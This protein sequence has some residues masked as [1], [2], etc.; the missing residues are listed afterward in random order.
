MN[1]L[2]FDQAA[3]RACFDKGMKDALGQDWFDIC[4]LWKIAESFGV[5]RDKVMAHPLYPSLL[6][7]H[8][9]H[10]KTMPPDMKDEVRRRIAQIFGLSQ[11]SPPIV[12]QEV[13][14]EILVYEIG[15][16]Q[17]TPKG[18]WFR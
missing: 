7:L 14:P 11:Q 3:S 15:S 10:W 1:D 5:K 16:K 18:G 2:E 6:K 17:A 13:K 4:G 12:V 9:V 8:C